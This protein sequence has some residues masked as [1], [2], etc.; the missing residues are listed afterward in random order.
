MHD[1]A[2]AHCAQS[3]RDF[4]DRKFPN[5]WIGRCGTIDWSARSSDLTPTDFFV[6][7][8]IKDRMYATKPGTLQAL[9]DAI[10]TE[11]ESL[12]VELCRR[13]CQSVPE[14]LQLCKEVEANTLNN[15][16]ENFRY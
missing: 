1:G 13:A 3:V 12:P 11:I 16:C 2:S 14:R 15:F 7:G 6:W 5:R 4:L 9:K 10:V 8:L